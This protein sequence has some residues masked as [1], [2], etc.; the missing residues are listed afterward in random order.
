MLEDELYQ[1]YAGLTKAEELRSL[2]FE[3]EVLKDIMARHSIPLPH[4]SL[5]RKPALAEVTIL[6][7]SSSH[8]HL[9]VKMPEYEYQPYHLASHHCP[10]SAEEDTVQDSHFPL[11]K[12]PEYL[13]RRSVGH[14]C[15]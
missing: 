6:G 2:Q 4:D 11:D 7:E 3:N 8:Q 13:Q 5:P 10:P 12:S 1:L 15:I 9:Q 14:S